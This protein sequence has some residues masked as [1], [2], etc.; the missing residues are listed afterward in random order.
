[1]AGRA[2]PVEPV[3]RWTA[4]PPCYD[5]APMAP[6][7]RFPPGRRDAVA[8]AVIF[9]AALVPR[10][11]Y[12]RDIDAAGLGS[13]LRLDP[14]YYHEWGRRIAAGDWL[15]TDAF[16]MSPLYPYALGALYALFGE[17]LTLPRMLQG[18][19]GAATCSATYL[20]GR[21]LFGWWAG[22]IAGALLAFYGPAIYYDG[23]INKTTLALALSVGFAWLLAVS[24]GRRR[25]WIAAGG[26]CLGLAALV[27][28]NVNV[29][30]PFLLAWLLAPREGERWRSR[31]P[32]ALCLVTG[33]AAAVLPVTIR[34]VAVSGEWVLIT[35]AGGE[36][37][38]TGNNP[39]ASGRYSPPPFVRPDP[40]F[41]H[42]DFRTEAARRLGRP[43]TRRESS[44]F[45]WREGL[46]F[47]ADRP[48]AFLWLLWDKLAVFMNA[49]E[50][51]DNFSYANFRLFS[52]TLSLPWAGFALVA[53]LA[54]VGLAA[55]IPRWRDLVPLYAGLGAYLIS[56]L[57]FFTQSRYR[58][59]AIP[60]FAI[61]AGH[62][63]ATLAA[64]AKER[65]ARDAA[66]CAAL[67]AGCFLFVTRDP[68]NAPGF[69]A[70]NDAIVGELYLHAGRYDE[71]AAS[72]RKGIAAMEPA[73]RAGNVLFARIVG[74][75][76]QGVGL[77]E[78]RRGNRASAEEAFRAAA[79]C[80]DPDVRREAL[81]ELIALHESRGDR[82]GAARALGEA[83]ALDPGSF[84]L[85]IRHA[86]ALYDA[87]SHD[88]ALGA[89]RAALEASP[90]PTPPQQSDA[91]YGMAMVHAARR[92]PGAAREA[93]DRALA[94]APDHAGAL[95]LRERLS[96]EGVQP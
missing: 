38:Y 72:F 47:I 80:P 56:A 91:W 61:F 43:V 21:R 4:G 69:D 82:A 14:L 62:G 20:L 6:S 7:D 8:A 42:E 93:L 54:T 71:A 27:H 44:Q 41:E 34:N 81:R 59:P 16:E 83:V 48:G 23:Q 75:A 19:L 74:A 12:V 35:S 29:A 36:N 2:G 73:A 70:Q 22:L 86:R 79:S 18:I 88:E 28:E 40:F 17:G 3:L 57:V 55:S 89:L 9:V 84:A 46:R 13:F 39:G 85:R 52:P 50:R 26:A 53:P 94:L 32:G 66:L 33:W 95:A 45:W 64:L 30:L 87:G 63:A 77:A 76:Q 24:G 25:A 90:P 60:F 68:G 37:F 10:I 92:D 67:A 58:M 96:R 65:R 15:G 5:F 11:L 49:F 31:L 78:A 1:M 51:P